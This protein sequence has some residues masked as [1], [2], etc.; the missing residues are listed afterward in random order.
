MRAKV[1]DDDQHST[2]TLLEIGKK[3]VESLARD[4]VT[5]TL[6][7]SCGRFPDVQKDLNVSDTM[8]Q[9]TNTTNGTFYLFNA[10]L[11]DRAAVNGSVVR[12]LGLINRIRPTVKTYCQMWFVGII[13]P[14]PVEVH[15]YR[16]LWPEFWGHNTDGA[17]PYLITCK[18]PLASHG[19]LPAY[20]S[21]VEDKCSYANNMFPVSNKRPS[22]R[23]KSF[24]V[25]WRG[26]NFDDDISMQVVEWAEIL[27]IFEVDKVIV[28]VEKLHENVM[29]VLHHYRCQGF[30]II[31]FIKF[32]HEFPNRREQNFLQWLQ[33]DL[34]SYHDAF[35]EHLY[36]YE[37][38]IPMDVDEFVMPLLDEDRSWH[39]LIRRT[40]LRSTNNKQI[41]DAYPV[42]N[43][44][45]LLKSEHEPVETIP[46]KFRFLS[47][48]YRAENFTADG[49]GAKTFMRMERVLVLH[50]HFPVTCIDPEYCHGIE[51]ETRVGQLS[52][53]RTDCDGEECVAS[54]QHPVKDTRLW[55]YKD[56]ILENVYATLSSM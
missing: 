34:I 23:R 10:Y 43:M 19:L 40:N 36:Q 46:K 31:K 44:Y 24:L 41:I 15:E 51:V 52:H 32:P 21:L 50:N 22:G 30:F 7:P 53:Y 33:S 2:Q 6:F 5:V 48:I 56:E 55:K 16:V 12:I 20:V 11:D 27:K 17:S 35:Y 47:N 42:L 1:I 18:N 45:F 49:G 28:Y 4:N 37:F 39:D 54:M 38:M 8:W 26:A 14:I 13:Q 25:C 9:V 3:Y 29:K